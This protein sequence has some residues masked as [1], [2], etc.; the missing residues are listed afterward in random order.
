MNQN[1]ARRFTLPSISSSK[2]RSRSSRIATAVT[3]FALMMLVAAVM[4]AAAVATF[5]TTASATTPFVTANDNDEAGVRTALL[6]SAAGFERGE[7]ALLDKVYVNDE[8]VTIFESG[9]ANYGWADYR[10]H[11]LVPE[12][13]EFKN[14]KYTLSDI[15]VKVS[16]NT[17]WATYKYELTGDL[18]D[19]VID[20]KGLGTA[21]LERRQSLWLIVH[22]HTSATPGRRAAAAARDR[23]PAPKG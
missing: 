11:H 5:R 17:A 2:G 8:S 10:D 12:M 1:L 14:T 3:V 21:V 19:R 23:G 6:Q 16:G 20:V 9:Y 15:R 4:V 18:K 13:K 22:S 7:L